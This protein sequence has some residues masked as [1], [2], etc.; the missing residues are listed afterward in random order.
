MKI[1][2]QAIKFMV[3]RHKNT[4]AGRSGWD[5]LYQMNS[6]KDANYPNID[7]VTVA[8]LAKAFDKYQKDTAKAFAKYQADTNY[9][10]CMANNGE[11]VLT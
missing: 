1:S 8:D 7:Y 10:I 6:V 11:L 2:E 9:R 3:E 5:N 4:D